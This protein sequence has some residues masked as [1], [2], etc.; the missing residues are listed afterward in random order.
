MTVFNFLREVQARPGMYLGYDPQHK[1]EQLRA[2]E[3]M[4]RGYSFALSEHSIEEPGLHFFGDFP[5][6]IASRGWKRSP[7][8]PVFA[9]LDAAAS[10]DEAWDDF[11]RLIWDYEATLTGGH[12]PDPS[13]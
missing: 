7:L 3:T 2:L 5:K 1:A 8:G 11:W 12:P 9:I 6:Y 13:R 4:L 10:P